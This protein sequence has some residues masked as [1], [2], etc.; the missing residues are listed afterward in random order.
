M[1]E[2]KLDKKLARHM[3]NARREIKK[4]VERA[5]KVDLRP[6]HIAEARRLV[7][8][9]LE[10]CDRLIVEVSAAK[11]STPGARYCPVHGRRSIDGYN[12][13][14]PEFFCN[15]TVGYEHGIPLL[16]GEPTKGKG[17]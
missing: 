17:T 3:A 6:G 16:C 4:A 11:G 12:K 5:E 8:A 2:P 13:S 14:A 7:Q 15:Q 10:E 1:A 9:A